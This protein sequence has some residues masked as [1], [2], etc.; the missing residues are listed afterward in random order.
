MEGNVSHWSSVL[1][2]MGASR[3]MVQW[4]SAQSDPETAWQTCDRPGWLMWAL[5]IAGAE[6]RILEGWAREYLRQHAIGQAEGTLADL[7]RDQRWPLGDPPLLLGCRDQIAVGWDLVR[8]HAST[9]G[10]DSVTLL[11]FLPHVLAL[12]GAIADPNEEERDA[13]NAI[14]RQIAAMHEPA[15]IS[16]QVITVFASGP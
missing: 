16:R 9:V 8:H 11:V 14:A 6:K 10:P 1:V 15:E 5:A 4:A 3:E 12:R 13:I 7:L 2:Q